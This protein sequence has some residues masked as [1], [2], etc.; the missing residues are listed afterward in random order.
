MADRERA[1]EFVYSLAGA[2]SDDRL[3]WHPHCE[4][5]YVTNLVGHHVFY[6]QESKMLEVL[7][8]GYFGVYPH[9]DAKPNDRRVI[10]GQSNYFNKPMRALQDAILNQQQKLALENAKIS[11][12]RR[13][14]SIIDKVLEGVNRLLN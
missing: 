5:I 7:R 1:L 11:T 2:T 6:Y 4:D 9:P 13:D 10:D 8:D 12:T 14:E 3:V